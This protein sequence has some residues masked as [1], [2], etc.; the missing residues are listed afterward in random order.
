M[1]V[2]ERESSS[3]KDSITASQEGLPESA[4]LAEDSRNALTGSPP[5]EPTDRHRH[6]PGGVPINVFLV[7]L[8]TENSERQT[9]SWSTLCHMFCF[10]ADFQ[11]EVPLIGFMFR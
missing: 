2:R 10:K 5:R 11:L 3:T 9:V 6:T 7:T 4:V 1:C 8:E